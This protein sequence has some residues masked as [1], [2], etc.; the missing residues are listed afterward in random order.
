MAVVLCSLLAKGIS[1][2]TVISW[3]KSE[4]SQSQVYLL[5]SLMSNSVT[6]NKVLLITYSVNR[7]IYCLS[8][9]FAKVESAIR[10]VSYRNGTLSQ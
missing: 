9:R 5:L 3:L 6:K 1:I 8:L 4:D 10:K 2:E 7:S